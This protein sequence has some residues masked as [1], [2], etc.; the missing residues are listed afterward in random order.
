M[1]NISSQ[2]FA[3]SS[4]GTDAVNNAQNTGKDKTAQAK[5]AL[6][7]LVLEEGLGSRLDALKA[8]TSKTPST[9]SSIDAKLASFWDGML[10][11][12]EERS[13][14][15]AIEHDR[16]RD[17]SY[18]RSH[19]RQLESAISQMPNGP[20]KD[21]AASKLSTFIAKNESRIERQ[22]QRAL[23]AEQS[24]NAGVVRRLLGQVSIDPEM[25]ASKTT[26]PTT[27]SLTPSVIDADLASFWDGMLDTFEE[28]T[29]LEAIEHDH[30][31]D[32][33][34]LHGRGEQLKS[35]ISQMP[36]GPEKDAAASKLSNFIAKN[37][38]RIE[39]QYQSALAA[40]Q[41]PR[42]GPARNLPRE[43]RIEPE[44]EAFQTT[45]PTA[46]SLTPS[47]IDADLS[48]FWDDMMDD[49]AMR[50]GRDAVQHNY[51]RDLGHLED[52][53]GQLD[54]KISRMPDGPEKD[55]AASTLQRFADDQK[56]RIEQTRDMG[57]SNLTGTVPGF[58][59]L[60]TPFPPSALGLFEEVG[61]LTN[62]LQNSSQ[63]RR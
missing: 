45:S 30:S 33:N 18:L 34:Y 16:G 31:R 43:F 3:S 29:G 39:R 47:V 35:S 59:K 49:A 44:S 12:F 25:E 48:S 11:T 40:E 4:L 46:K 5:E 56:Q 53:L 13:G 17:L 27:K 6:R 15:E 28:R 21:A 36:N 61:A 8:I 23:A 20:E 38:S 41:S 10:D 54:R 52:K 51:V 32:L 63:S 19:G 7:S 42:T 2:R 57:L 62:E 22:Y 50:Y 26:S 55:T 1:D 60:A 37:E 9:A 14:L 24:P 58:P